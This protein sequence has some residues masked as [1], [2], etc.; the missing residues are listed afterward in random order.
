MPDSNSNVTV[1]IFDTS[2][3]DEKQN[4]PVT[5]TNSKRGKCNRTVHLKS[6][7]AFRVSRLGKAAIKGMYCTCLGCL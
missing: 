6:E 4:N 2:E 3:S 1:H 5:P 7:T